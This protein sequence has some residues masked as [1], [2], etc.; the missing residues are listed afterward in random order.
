MRVRGTGTRE[1]AD[2]PTA[3]KP[4]SFRDALVFL[5]RA[6]FSLWL[7]M[8]TAPRFPGRRDIDAH[9]G[10]VSACTR[11][12]PRC[13]STSDGSS[14]QRLIEVS[15]HMVGIVFGLVGFASGGAS[16]SIF[17]SDPDRVVGVHDRAVMPPTSRKR[18]S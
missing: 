9:L 8:T 13:A 5:K 6:G 18:R 2:R 4:S 12:R 3:S 1:R 15:D 14:F 17:R 11:S 7:E 16:R 10:G